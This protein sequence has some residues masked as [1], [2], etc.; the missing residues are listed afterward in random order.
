MD[1][2]QLTF[3]ILL[4]AIAYSFLGGLITKNYSQVD[5]LWSV[6]PPV[7]VL[8]WMKDFSSNPRYVIAAVLVVLWGIR[9]TTNFAIKGGY[10]FSFKKGFYGED[11]RWDVLKAKIPNPVLFELFNLFFISGFQLGLIYLFTLP[12]YYLG[13]QTGPLTS[14]DY[15]LFALHFILLAGEMT[16]D[17]QQ[18]TYYK[19]RS[20]EAEKNNRRIQL[21]FNTLGLWKYSRH[22]NYVC[23]L[24]QWF[25][26]YF[27]L[28]S[29]VGLHYTLAG[30]VVLLALFVGS[31]IMAENITA[32]KYEGYI[33]WKK[34]TAP[35]LPLLAPLP[36]RKNKKAFLAEK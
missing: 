3:Y 19:K 14:V 22:P 21:G 35:W 36:E 6:L 28:H 23:E 26:V 24:G 17:I 10:A 20:D 13:S 4:A 12:L 18:L 11:Y 9:L 25:V 1:T 16:A 29:R 33:R 30:P 15:I 27:Y 7:Y 2:L 31:T 8:I 32:G 34:M 5:R